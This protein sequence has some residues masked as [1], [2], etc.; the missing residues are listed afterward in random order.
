MIINVGPVG[1]TGINFLA[2]RNSCLEFAPGCQFTQSDGVG[3][4]VFHLWLRKG[5]TALREV[6]VQPVG[7]DLDAKLLR[8]SSQQ[9]R[10]RTGGVCG[11]QE[12]LRHGPMRW[13]F[14]QHELNPVGPWPGGP[15]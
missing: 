5:K 9:R 4:L 15:C 12:R 10:F 3:H 13:E 7:K 6:P 2:S 14:E 1:L 8:L 11:P